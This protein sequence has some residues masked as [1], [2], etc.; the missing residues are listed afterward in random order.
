MHWIALV[1]LWFS[2]PEKCAL[3]GTV[4]NSFTGEPL[5]KVE[6]ALEPVERGTNYVAGTTSDAQGNFALAGVNPGRYR[7][8]VARNGYLETRGR[9]LQLEAGQ[10][11][12][13][14]RLKLIPAAVISGTIRDSDGQPI[15]AELT[16][17]RF[18]YQYGKP[19]V[20]GE[21]SAESDDRGEY[22]FR[23][24]APGKYYLGVEVRAALSYTVDLS[25]RAEE[26]ETSVP[27]LYPGVTDVNLATP[28]DVSPGAHLSGFD[29]TLIRSHTWRVGG[30]V[31]NAPASGKVFLSL[32]N[33]NAAGM[34]N[35][36]D[37]ETSTTSASGDFEFRPVPPGSYVLSASSGTLTSRSRINVGA[38]DVEGLRLTLA[39]SADVKANVVIEGPGKP[40]MTQVTLFLTTDG[41]HGA[42]GRM[43][44]GG[45][46]IV[47][48]NVAPD[49]YLIG[50]D[51]V[52]SHGYYVKSIKA[53]E[54]DLLRDGLDVTGSEPIFIE[55]AIA[56][57]GAIAQGMVLD[58]QE[59]PVPEATVLLAPEQR[60]RRDLYKSTTTDQFGHYE[61]ASIAPGTYKVFAWHDVEPGAW[62]D[63]EFLKPYEKQ[64]EAATLESRTRDTVN[65]H[66]AALAESK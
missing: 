21:D 34:R 42:V 54:S 6:L 58:K 26:I 35:S 65:V 48:G 33:P 41:R 57:D 32:K 66:S 8:K 27:T 7:L 13:D 46:V 61:M 15:E 43:E 10:N 56:P 49:H 62:D 16:L 37:A 11:L 14:L 1:L 30:R 63:P 24:I 60:S 51:A 23:G 53:G 9:L 3:S 50:Y 4:V 25:A 18:T 29:I 12:T 22:R 28:I 39:P 40:D 36:A 38:A 44:Q 2:P 45:K 20:E 17:G 47:L 64:G 31:I 5:G 19:R 52:L 55:V 59:Q